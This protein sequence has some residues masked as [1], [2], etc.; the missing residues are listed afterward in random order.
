MGFAGA[1]QPPA[2]APRLPAFPLPVAFPAPYG[3]VASVC[4]EYA[5][6]MPT[7]SAA[8]PAPVHSPHCG[9]NLPSFLGIVI[10][11]SKAL[12]PT[13]QRP[14]VKEPR[15]PYTSGK[16]SRACAG[17]TVTASFPQIARRS[18]IRP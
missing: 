17:T 6:V 4:L 18:S 9:R 2:R 5:R 1:G 14:G 12:L 7:R 3:A 10:G 8:R 13:T 16:Q 15:K 11:E